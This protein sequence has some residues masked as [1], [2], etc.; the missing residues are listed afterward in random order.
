MKEINPNDER[1]NE[2]CNKQQIVSEPHRTL[3]LAADFRRH[4]LH[5]VALV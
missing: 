5:S 1:K 3:Q 4:K 2:E